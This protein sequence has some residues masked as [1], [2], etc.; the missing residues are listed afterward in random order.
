MRVVSGG[1][2]NGAAAAI[3][4]EE[5]KTFFDYTNKMHLTYLDDT[6]ELIWMSERDGWNH[7]Y[8]INSKTGEVKN[9][10]TKGPWVVRSVDEVDE[11]NRMI[12]FK[13][14]GIY[15]DQDPYYQHVVRISFDGTH[16]GQSN[17]GRWGPQGQLLARQ[18]RYL[19]DSYS[20]V[21]MPDV[22]ELR[23]VS[24]GSLVATLE[25]GDMSA[26]V[27][28]GYT[29]PERFV[30]KAR[31]GKTDIFGV[32]I[33]PT[34]FDPARKYPVIENIYAGPQGAFV[35]KDFMRTS[36]I[37]GSTTVAEFSGVHRGADGWYGDELPFQGVS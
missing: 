24:D 6:G 5:V 23:K 25:K 29:V 27:A 1:C 22:T 7:L 3:V 2:G 16:S 10:I 15:P 20:R 35:P 17:R 26:L 11:K 34:H 33:R 28:A 21:D 32:I 36:T 13:A 4:N 30:A 19:V 8:L 14:G 9:Q 37:N 18:R 31:D 12:W